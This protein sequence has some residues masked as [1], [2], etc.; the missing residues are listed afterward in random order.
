ML[1][2][3]Q[4]WRNGGRFDAA[5]HHA[6]L[7]HACD[8]GVKALLSARYGVRELWVIDARRR[9]AFVHRGPREHGTWVER[10]T[11]GE[12]DVLSH[13]AVPGFSPRL[14]DI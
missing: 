10:L 1:P 7:D 5:T 11:L 6:S 12:G 8:R 14:G 3:A 13:P 9:R 4:E 2:R